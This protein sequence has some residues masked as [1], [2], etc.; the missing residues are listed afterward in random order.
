MVDGLIWQINVGGVGEVL[1]EH[2]CNEFA[3]NGIVG[4]VVK[5]ENCPL[6][7]EFY[8]VEDMN[9]FFVVLLFI[10]PV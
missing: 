1:I 7:F 9:C 8:H 4:D 3:G 2:A 6:E 5:F 10:E